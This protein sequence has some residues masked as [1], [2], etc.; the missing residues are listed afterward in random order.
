MFRSLILALSIALAAPAA[1]QVSR[2]S[3][4]ASPKLKELVT[5]TS[6]VV[7][8][9]DLVDNAGSAVDIPVFRS[10]E[11]GHT[12]S[13]SV[14]RVS[15]AL[16]SHR[17]EDIDTGDFTEVVVTR[18]SRAITGREIEARIARALAGQHGFGDA[19]N[20]A[21]TLSRSVR[22]M[23]VEPFVTEEL[24]VARLAFEPRSHRFDVV[25][26]L[27][28]SEVARRLP[29]RFTGTAVETVEAAILVRAL[30]RGEVVK[31][32]DIVV[33]RRPKIEASGHLGAEEV[34]GLAAKRPLRAGTLVRANDL[35]KP[36]LVQRNEPVTIVYEA[37]GILLTVRGKAL[38][39]GGK[40]DLISV[41]NTQSQRT[42]Q[43]TITGPGRVGIA[44]ATPLP[45]GEATATTPTT[46]SSRTE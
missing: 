11:L 19:E 4:S 18:L 26:E 33:E 27:P 36:E 10:P 21:V 30:G 34:I 43:A 35:M 16:R 25:F 37:P 1:A 14:A 44:A 40:G 41:L 9:G 31:P 22:A 42:V 17:I 20:I 39:S 24:Q 12:G 8:I 29:L 28:G 3:A 46:T 7:R 32:S 23:H 2:T 5:V 45:A 13:V 38:E 6:D 15:A